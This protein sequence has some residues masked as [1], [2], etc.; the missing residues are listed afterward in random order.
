MAPG[1]QF[2]YVFDLG[3]DWTHLCTVGPERIDPEK[4]GFRDPTG[5][6]HVC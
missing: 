1:E 2:V 6:A 4:S 5:W 3:D